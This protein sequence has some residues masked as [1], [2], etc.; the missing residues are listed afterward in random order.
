MSTLPASYVAILAMRPHTIKNYD[1]T[2]YNMPGVSRK[3]EKE[4]MQKYG[5]D[6]TKAMAR[7]AG[8]NVIAT[9]TQKGAT[10]MLSILYPKAAA[11]NSG[12]AAIV[13]AALVCRDY[14]LNPAMDHVFLI[15]FAGNWAVVRGI[16]ASRLICGREKSYGYI[17][18][19][20]RIMT[21]DE[22]MRI[23]GEVDDKSSLSKSTV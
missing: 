21:P 23:Y 18:D 15:E 22:Q 19:T 2:G 3:K 8:G 9:L 6:K 20:P 14:G 5:E 1:L 16:K 13:K 11:S 17:D 7:A 4:M 12:K 10:E